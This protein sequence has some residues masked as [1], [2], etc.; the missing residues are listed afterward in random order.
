MVVVVVVGAT[1]VV[2]GATVV[3]VGA[4]V[5]VVGATVVVVGATVVELG[6]TVVVVGGAGVGVDALV[7]FEV[8][9]HT[10]S[11]VGVPATSS[12]LP[13]RQTVN[14]L[15]LLELMVVEKVPLAQLPQ[16]RSPR[17]L[18]FEDSAV[19]GWQTVAGWQDFLSLSR[20]SVSR[21]HV[22]FFWA[23]ASAT[24]TNTTITMI[25]SCI[26]LQESLREAWK[27]KS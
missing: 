21:W 25:A 22:G 1:V 16:V 10:R 7:V 18:S 19:P 24:R 5:V 26:I 14:F 13:R 4:T 27:R 11:E 17:F 6:A 2:V 15:H 23:A 3:V 12:T 9:L 8:G 20:N